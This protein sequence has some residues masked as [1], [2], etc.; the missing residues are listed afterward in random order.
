MR[1]TFNSTFKF[2]VA[3]EAVMG[4]KTA[5]ELASIHEV[6][7]SQISNWKSDLL[8]NGKQLF[9]K[10][11]G[12]KKVQ[13]SNNPDYLLR[14]IGQLKI[15]RDFLAKKYNDFQSVRGD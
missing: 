14:E 6:S 9:D 8:K 1:K 12:P 2:K 15:E 10:K 7:V 4:E 5:A 11:R 3:L 13:P